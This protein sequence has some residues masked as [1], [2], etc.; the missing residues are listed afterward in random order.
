MNKKMI[1]I[2]LVVLICIIT[3]S[4]IFF[5]K[6]FVDFELVCSLNESKTE[7]RPDAYRFFHSQQELTDFFEMNNNTKQIQE[8]LPDDIVFDFDKYSYCIVYGNKINV[9]YHS[10]KTTFFDDLSP[11]YASCRKDGKKCVFIKYEDNM[12]IGNT[13]IY[14][15]NHDRDLRGFDGI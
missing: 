11:S 15:I 1:L 13:Y 9:M 6:S 10:F 14:R 4:F 7:Y 3:L 2:A 5:K 12:K 8:Q